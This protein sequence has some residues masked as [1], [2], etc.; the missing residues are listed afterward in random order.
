MRSVL[1]QR[2]A[3]VLVMIPDY[4]KCFMASIFW[5]ARGLGDLLDQIKALDVVVDAVG[6]S[7]YDWIRW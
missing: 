7:A 2:F 3:V 6:L 4:I 1:N 5:N